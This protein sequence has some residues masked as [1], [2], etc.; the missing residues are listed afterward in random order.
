[1]PSPFPRWAPSMSPGMSATTKLRPGLDS[2][3]AQVGHK[4]GKGVVRD[5]GTS[6][7]DR[8]DQRALSRIGETDQTNICQNLQLELDLPLLARL[9]HF[10]ATGSLIG[11]GGKLSIS[12]STTPPLGNREG[13]TLVEEFPQNAPCLRLPDEGP[14]WNLQ[15]GMRPACT[16]LAGPH[17][18]LSSLSPVG[19]AVTVVQESGKLS[20]AAEEDVS[21]APAI[22][23]VRPSLRDIFLAPETHAPCST[24]A[25]LDMNACSINELHDEVPE[26]RD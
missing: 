1:M 6:G 21:A 25:A 26:Y 5:L 16:R 22:A 15:D 9:S 4:R 18:V 23:A 11:R 17:P 14:Q 13:I 12:T 7:R 19:C 3:D 8:R 10:I 2:Y 24:I 20:V